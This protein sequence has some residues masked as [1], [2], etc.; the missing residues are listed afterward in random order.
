MISFIGQRHSHKSSPRRRFGVS[1]PDRAE[2]NRPKWPLHG[3]RRCLLVYGHHPYLPDSL[4]YDLSSIPCG[5]GERWPVHHADARQSGPRHGAQV[6][7][8]FV[9]A[10]R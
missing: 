9:S 8:P 5:T 1:V 6:A 10:R 7:L 3:L 4:G 2:K